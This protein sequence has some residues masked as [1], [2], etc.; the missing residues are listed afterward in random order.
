MKQI[1][2]SQANT[3]SACPRMY[4]FKYIQRLELVTPPTEDRPFG[5]A[6]HVAYVTA[7][8]TGSVDDAVKAFEDA[9]DY[10]FDTSI[11]S[12]KNVA[13][14]RKALEMMLA[15][16]VGRF[17]DAEV[18]VYTVSN[19][20]LIHGVIDAIVEQ[21]DGERVCV[22][23][24]S[25]GRDYSHAEIDALFLSPQFHIYATLTGNCPVVVDAFIFKKEVERRVFPA[26]PTRPSVAVMSDVDMWMSFIQNAVESGRFPRNVNSCTRYGRCEYLNIC[27]SYDPAD[28]VPIG[29]R[30]REESQ[31]NQGGEE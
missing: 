16:P 27:A 20:T 8:K 17:I 29:Y 26:V 12:Y 30:I 25:R 14:V 5:R 21:P 2:F 22:E 7:L 28:G 24:K 6:F 13:N 4:F 31:H 23:I 3:F 9:Y 19:D 15:N 10:P 1:S 11:A 18:K